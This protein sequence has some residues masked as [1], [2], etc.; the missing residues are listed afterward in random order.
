MYG[1]TA[2]SLIVIRNVYG[3]ISLLN[4]ELV[5]DLNSVNMLEAS[6]FIDQMFKD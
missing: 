3:L 4:L 2:R 5:F 1:T 6:N